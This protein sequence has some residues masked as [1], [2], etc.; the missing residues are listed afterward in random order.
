[1]LRIMVGTPWSVACIGSSL[2]LCNKRGAVVKS[3][4]GA[5]VNLVFIQHFQDVARARFTVRRLERT[6]GA[7]LVR[8]AYQ[9]LD[10]AAG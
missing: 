10:D 7:D 6:Y 2:F 3:G 1:M 9:R 4:S 8:E 5:L